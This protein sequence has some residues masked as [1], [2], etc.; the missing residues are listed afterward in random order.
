M[1]Y[2]YRSKSCYDSILLLEKMLQRTFLLSSDDKL[3]VAEDELE[4]IQEGA[5][6]HMKAGFLSHK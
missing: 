3:D 4:Y 1:D 2:H 6:L 5:N